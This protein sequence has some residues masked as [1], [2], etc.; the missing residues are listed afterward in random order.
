MRTET[1]LETKR[2]RLTNWAPEHVDDLMLLHG[3]PRVTR[4]FSPEGKAE[5]RA[6]AEERLAHW[7]EL[8]STR[9]LGKLRVT[10]R[11]SGA[12]LGRAGYGVH[13]AD[14]TPEIGYAF[15]PDHWGKGYAFEAA[16]ALRDWYFRETDGGH[17]IGFADSDHAASLHILKKIGMTPTHTE[18]IENGMLCQFLI[19]RREDWPH[20]D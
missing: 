10:D 9:R 12:F 14:A 18:T 2:L 13:G 19:Y 3:D 20:H 6:R 7:A 4:F 1:V 17:F 11:E 8:F 5:D 15:L 16:S